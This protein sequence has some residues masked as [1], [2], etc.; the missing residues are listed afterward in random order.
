[1]ATDCESSVGLVSWERVA[2]PEELEPGLPPLAPGDSYKV[3]VLACEDH[4][5]PVEQRTSVH[6][7]VCTAPPTCDCPVSAAP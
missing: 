3:I 6:D 5:I 1:M 4:E 7:A 2:R